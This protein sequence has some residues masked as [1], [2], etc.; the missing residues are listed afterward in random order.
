MLV[1]EAVALDSRLGLTGELQRISLALSNIEKKRYAETAKPRRK[2]SS[3]IRLIEMSDDELKV[4]SGSRYNRSDELEKKG[5]NAPKRKRRPL[6][7]D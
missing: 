7:T 3:R 4:E 6:R 5:L 1:F 2:F